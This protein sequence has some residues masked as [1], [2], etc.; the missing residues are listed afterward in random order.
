MSDLCSSVFFCG[1]FLCVFLW[2]GLGR[3]AVVVSNDAGALDVRPPVLNNVRAHR[4]RE[5]QVK[6]LLPLERLWMRLGAGKGHAR[7]RFRRLAT[8]GGA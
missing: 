8:V 2:R 6:H 3:S 4:V 5:V 1:L 7:A